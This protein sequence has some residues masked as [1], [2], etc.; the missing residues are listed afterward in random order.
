M[1][2]TTSRNPSRKTRRFARTLSGIF[3]WRYLTRGK[4][5]IEELLWMSERRGNRMG[6]VSEIKG[7]P[8][9]IHFFKSD[10]KFISGLRISPG[11]IEKISRHTSGYVLFTDKIR[12]FPMELF[13][14]AV[15]EGHV[16]GKFIK[17]ISPQYRVEVLDGGGKL[18][19]YDGDSIS[20]SFRVLEVIKRGR[21]LV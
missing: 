9:F 2:L 19:F 17:K 7:N 5:S 20:L 8:A 12:G 4:L 11:V 10:G 15:V 18:I 21:D 13:E 6:I 16:P 3:G 14:N 1:L